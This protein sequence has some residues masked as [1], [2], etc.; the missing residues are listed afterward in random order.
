MCFQVPK[1]TAFQVIFQAPRF[2][3]TPSSKMSDVSMAEISKGVWVPRAKAA[4]NPKDICGNCML[5]ECVECYEYSKAV[6]A[7]PVAK[8]MNPEDDCC[9]CRLPGYQC[10]ECRAEEKRPLEPVAA[11]THAGATMPPALAPAPAGVDG[12]YSREAGTVWP[13][14]AAA[15]PPLPGAWKKVTHRKVELGTE[16]HEAYEDYSTHE[17][18]EVP[19][20]EKPECRLTRSAV[21][22]NCVTAWR[23]V[24]QTG[25]MTGRAWFVLEVRLGSGNS[26]RYIIY[27]HQVKQVLTKAS[28]GS[29]VEE[30]IIDTSGAGREQVKLRFWGSDD[31]LAFHVTLAGH[32]AYHSA[33]M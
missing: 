4:V 19:H 2:S 8:V 23:I 25:G 27:N 29:E 32:L 28:P 13:A 22:Y 12:Y 16:F 21:W 9:G 11:G 6:R 33:R 24:P 3:K 20:P 14:A 5:E 15:P 30:V 10:P 1:R 7:P 31:A 18:L 26:L 17:W